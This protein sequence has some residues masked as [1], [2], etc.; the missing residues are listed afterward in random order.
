[1]GDRGKE[2]DNKAKGAVQGEKKER[3]NKAKGAVQ[4]RG[5]PQI[6]NKGD[7]QLTVRVQGVQQMAN[8]TCVTQLK[9]S[10]S[11]LLAFSRRI[12]PAVR[13]FL[14]KRGEG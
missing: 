2:R 1:M 3:D 6:E 9:V 4:A 12:F 10:F 8:L 11:P 13:I 5:K 7:Q 14:R